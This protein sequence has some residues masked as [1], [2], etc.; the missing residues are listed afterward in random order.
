[1]SQN[2]HRPFQWSA[3]ATLAALAVPPIFTRRPPQLDALAPL[4]G[5]GSGRPNKYL[6]CP[7]RRRGV[8]NSRLARAKGPGSYDAWKLSLWAERRAKREGYHHE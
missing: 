6:G 5:F 1:M 3:A 2:I 8:L 7:R 4:G